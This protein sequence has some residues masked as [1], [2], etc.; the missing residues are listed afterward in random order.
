MLLL[1]RSSDSGSATIRKNR[2]RRLHI[3]S[4]I[5]IAGQRLS[6]VC[7]PTPHPEERSGERVAKDV[8]WH[9]LVAQLVRA[10]A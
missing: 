3:P 1:L 7:P 6:V 4:P 9:G 10:R 5:V 2:R 8:L